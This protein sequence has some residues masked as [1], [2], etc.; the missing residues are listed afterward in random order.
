MAARKR[1]WTPEV[2][3]QRI[4]T[5]MLL[6][7]LQ[8]HVNDPEKSTMSITQLKAATFLLSRVV[9]APTEPQDLNVNGNMTYVFRNPTERPPQMTNG[10]HRTQPERDA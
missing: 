10:H 1:T 5:S 7:R 9:P 4:K 2:V 3:R 8:D 6:K